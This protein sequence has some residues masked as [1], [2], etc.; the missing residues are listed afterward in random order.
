MVFNMSMNASTGAGTL[1][2][3][4]SLHS[5]PLASHEAGFANMAHNPALVGKCSDRLPFCCP[6]ISV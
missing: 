2:L 5:M 3:A 6:C 1:T 4:A